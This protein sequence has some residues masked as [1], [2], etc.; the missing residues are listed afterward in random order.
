MVSV[1]IIKIKMEIG[2]MVEKL[3]NLMYALT[4]YDLDRA[5]ALVEELKNYT[6]DEDFEQMFEK[7]KMAVETVSYD[8]G[9][10]EIEA[11]LKK[12]DK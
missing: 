7:V 11:F 2:T 8:S 10:A 12:Y 4:E 6:Y 9:I 5:D 3:N 1:I